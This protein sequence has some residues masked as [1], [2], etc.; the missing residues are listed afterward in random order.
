MIAKRALP[1][2]GMAAREALLHY[3]RERG[4]YYDSKEGS[5]EVQYGGQRGVHVLLF[6][7]RKADIAQGGYNF[8]V[9]ASS[10]VNTYFS[11]SGSSNVNTYFSI[12]GSSSVIV[13]C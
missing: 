2:C 5:T 10:N 4:L 11:I 13:Q 7:A 9:L 8:S 3:K 12:S 1:R 6:I